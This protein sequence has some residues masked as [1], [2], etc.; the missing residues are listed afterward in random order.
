MAGKPINHSGR[1]FG[2]L[3]AVELAG[4]RPGGEGAI[5]LCHCDCGSVVRVRATSLVSGNTNSCGCIVKESQWTAAE[6]KILADSI[7]LISFQKIA[8]LLPGRS[9]DAIK[10]RADLLGLHR[11]NRHFPRR[12]LNE[13]FFSQGGLLP[14]YWAGFIAAD[15]CVVISPRQELR[16]GLNKKDESHLS[17]FCQDIGF[18]GKLGFGKKNV[19]RIAI[20]AAE[21]VNADL[22][23]HF[24]IGPRKTWSLDPPSLPLREALAYTV[25]YIDGDGCWHRG[26]RSGILQLIIVGRKQILSWMK[27]LWVEAGA[28]V[29]NVNVCTVKDKSCHRLAISGKNAESVADLL[30][31]IRVPKLERKWSITIEKGGKKR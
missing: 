3:T 24:R 26:K 9:V 27:E 11:Q 4:S 30:C 23:R 18:D 25:G 14:A 13:G 29:G 16:I 6:K 19:V 7:N 2:K 17:R 20:C 21:K 12:A 28:T 10:R 31:D 1:R 8:K 15:G 22:W 5:W